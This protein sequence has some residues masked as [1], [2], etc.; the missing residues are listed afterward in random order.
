MVATNTL[1]VESSRELDAIAAQ[2][3]RLQQKHSQRSN[4]EQSRR[5]LTT[6]TQTLSCSVKRKRERRGAGK[7]RRQWQPR[8]WP[9]QASQAVYAELLLLLYSYTAA[10]V[11]SL[12][13]VEV[14]EEEEEEED[15]TNAAMAGQARTVAAAAAV[16]R[17]AP[18]SW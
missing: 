2:R 5:R 10:Y 9:G 18:P 13:R 15:D 12:L 3:H 11:A 17:I 4:F 6:H 14:Q 7:R 8:W 1:W 16:A